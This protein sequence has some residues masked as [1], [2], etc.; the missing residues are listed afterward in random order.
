MKALIFRTLVPVLFAAACPAQETAFTKALRQAQRGDC[1]AAAVTLSDAL[2]ARPAAGADYYRL[3]ADCQLQTG[4]P[5]DA[6]TTLRNGLRR[7]PASAPMEKSLGIALFRQKAESVEAGQRLARAAKAL[8]RDP[9]ARHYFAQWA[10]LNLR[11]RICISEEQSALRLPGLNEQALLQMNTLLGMCAT[12]LEDSP[13]A[14]K[15][16]A[17]AHAVNLRQPTLDPIAAYQYLTFLSRFADAASAEQVI[18]DVLQRVPRFGP[19]LLEQAK[20]RERAKDFAAAI[21][22]A[23]AS[24]NGTNNDINAER[25]AHGI[26]ARAYAAQ[27]DEAAAQREQAWIE[28]HPNPEAVRQ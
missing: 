19:A 1:S 28:S 2:R 3:L 21:D 27:G 18:A 16:F 9:E 7:F 10:Y 17:A 15:A 23:N 24:L 12:R 6:T 14:H 4:H 13:T 22:S 8:P 25:A 11:D 26:L 20:L 5:D